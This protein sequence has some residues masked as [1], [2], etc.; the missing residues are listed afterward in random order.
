MKNKENSNK[1]PKQKTEY[2]KLDEILKSLF[3]VSNKVLINM[4]NTI[5]HENYN[6]K[7]TT[8]TR[9]NTEFITPEYNVLKADLILELKSKKKNQDYHIEFQ[10]KNDKTMII[11]MFEYG[12][13]YAKQKY[14]QREENDEKILFYMPKSIVMYIEENKNISD[15]ID[16]IIVFPDKQEVTFKVPVMKCWEY[17]TQK[18]IKNKLYPLLPLQLFNLRKELIKLNKEKTENEDKITEQMQK[19][20][21][22]TKQTIDETAKL[23][24][25]KEIKPEDMH[26]ILL[27]ISNLF[28]YLNNKYGNDTKLNE[29]VEIMTK[30][31]YDPVVE[32]RGIRIG[33]AKGI[34]R[35]CIEFKLEKDEILNKLKS[36][37]NID[38]EKANK[39]LND[40]Y[41]ENKKD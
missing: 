2:I 18:M 12:F 33:E 7:D 9:R 41:N 28:Q 10:T 20:M 8:I 6:T 17:S 29:E 39:Y 14:D 3:T 23:E 38:D 36:N 26:T 1:S 4:I 11:R 24:E 35:T 30:T 15:E 40:Y 34:I 27:A 16:M 13:S 5:F 21:Q 32:A 31:L 22:I 37:L 19:V 25:N